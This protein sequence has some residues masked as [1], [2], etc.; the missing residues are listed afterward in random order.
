MQSFLQI[1]QI[2]AIGAALAMDGSVI[3]LVYG[4]KMQPF[5]L[6]LALIPALAFGIA[7][8]I[9]PVLG[10]LG[11]ELI[12][13]A[14]AAIDHWLAFGILAV[15][16]IKFIYDARS[17]SDAKPLSG[18]KFSAICAAALATSIDSCAVGLSLSFA[19]SPIIL[20]AILFA[21][22]T[23][24]FCLAAMRIGAAVGTRFGPS[25]MRFGGIVLIAMGSLILVEH[26]TA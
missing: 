24:V 22:I 8:G 21:S 23:F 9:M 15:L 6:R 5:R 11:G 13:D 17:V 16:G 7:Q 12:S 14:L 4:A 18:M 20:P 10:W 3:S 1:L 19:D 25:L 26:L 2:G